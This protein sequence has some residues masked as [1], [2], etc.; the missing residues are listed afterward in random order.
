MTQ[1]GCDALRVDAAVEICGVR[2]E[3]GIL[4]E[5]DFYVCYYFSCNAMLFLIRLM[6][7]DNDWPNDLQCHM[8][9]VDIARSAG[10]RR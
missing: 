10:N 1:A 5:P 4:P 3:V 8:R 2:K 6:G 9:F 7:N